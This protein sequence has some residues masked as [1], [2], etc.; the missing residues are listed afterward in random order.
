MFLTAHQEAPLKQ[1][2]VCPI[3]DGSGIAKIELP[4][5]CRSLPNRATCRPSVIFFTG[6][7][8]D[9]NQSVGQTSLLSEQ[10][11]PVKQLS[12]FRKHHRIPPSVT[13]ND[14]AFFGEL[15][16]GEL[17]EEMDHVF[18]ELR[19]TFGLKRKELSVFGPEEGRGT[20]TT[21][22]FT[23]E[24]CVMGY[25]PDPSKIVLRRSITQI[26]SP[27]D[28]FSDAFES[29]FHNQFRILEIVTRE[30]L[31]IESIVDHIEDAELDSV[32]VDYDKRVT[33]C[34]IQVEDSVVSIAIDANTIRVTSEKELA[35]RALLE[36]FLDI[37][38]KFIASLGNGE[39]IFLTTEAH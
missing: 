1:R 29:V 37:Q 19:S 34:K 20:I 35:P 26:E 28:V 24:I 38:K 4:D 23:Y 9:Q 8:M 2:G 5:H 3:L 7:M 22:A 36:S 18:S 27:G 32:S 25:P 13:E 39:D 21:P 14:L 11:V 31:D 17:D 33:W 30:P 15:A 6:L 16:Q 10:I 12:G